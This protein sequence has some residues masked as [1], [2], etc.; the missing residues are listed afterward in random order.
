VIL[1]IEVRWLSIATLVLTLALPAGAAIPDGWSTSDRAPL[2]IADFD[3]KVSGYEHADDV[4]VS[5]DGS[6]VF[7][8]GGTE[9]ATSGWDWITLA[10]RADG[11]R[12]WAARYDSPA[13]DDGDIARSIA[14]GPGGRVFVTGEGMSAAGDEWAVTI[15]YDAATGRPLW[16]RHYPNANP[17]FWAD[18]AYPSGIEL[19]PDGRRVFVAGTRYVGLPGAHS[20]DGRYAVWAYRASDGARLWTRTLNHGSRSE[21]VNAMTIDP[22]GR[23]VV[24]VGEG[25]NGFGVFAI[26][27]RDGSVAWYER[28]DPPGFQNAVAVAA[29]RGGVFVAGHDGNSTST[30]AY[31]I[32]TGAER[33]A[34]RAPG[35]GQASG[36]AASRS[37]GVVAVTGFRS[38]ARTG[39]DDMITTAYAASSG[40]ARWV[41]RERGP[42]YAGGEA[43][44][45][46]DTGERVAA[47]GFVVGR[48][49]VTAAY[50]ATSGQRLWRGYAND[51]EPG[52]DGGDA[53][54]AD[55]LGRRVYVVA[56]TQGGTDGQDI[57]TLA[58]RLG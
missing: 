40:A 17:R 51:G 16:A 33:W 53:I 44:L 3:G 55:R 32:G 42:R 27:S 26:R 35:E 23:I 57:A 39:E 19:S 34:T 5:P 37:G 24:G 11:A 13:E 31:E 22:S 41:T 14:T 6:R 54:A 25:G 8:T 9:T 56:T 20:T 58:Y 49:I 28:F 43:V 1:M 18:Y 46:T 52:W 21:T 45:I 4:A 15:A 50:A 48:G 38:N 12:L 47:T 2:W 29:S 36:I 10:Y 7:V 30:V